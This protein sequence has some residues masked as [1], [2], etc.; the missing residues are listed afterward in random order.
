MLN[1]SVVYDRDT[2]PAKLPN[3]LATFLPD[4]LVG[5][6]AGIWQRVLVDKSRMIITQIKEH[7]RSENGRNAWGALYHTAP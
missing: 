2:W 4:S 6:P 7:N 5:V 1:I 3:I